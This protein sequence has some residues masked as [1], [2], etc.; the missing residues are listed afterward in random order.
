VVS[1][2]QRGCGQ[3]LPNAADPAT[4]LSANTTAHLLAD[5][6]RLRRHLGIE[7][8][9][10]LGNS[11]GATLGLAYCEAHRDRATALI[12]Q[13][14]TTTARWEIDRLFGGLAA[15]FPEQWTAFRAAVPTDDG[16]VLAAYDR[17]LGDADAVVRQRAADAWHSWELC[18]I[19]GDPAA[20]MPEPWRDPRYRLTR[21]RICAHYFANGAFLEDGAILR[22]AHRLRGLPGVMVHGDA[23]VGSPLEVAQAL[24]AQWPEG[25]L[26]VVERAG[27]SAGGPGMAEAL[28]AAT[29][30]FAR[31]SLSR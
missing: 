24:A 6:E 15:R 30:R 2:D 23:D 12:L 10:V 5:I 3:S 16:D 11:W 19:F 9:L 21:A 17:A 13:A 25:E 29:G 31:P 4:D 26:V 28:L 7:R 20:P 18:T 22:D 27:H 1:F 8:W 14:V